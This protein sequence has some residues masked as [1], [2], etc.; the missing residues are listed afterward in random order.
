MSSNLTRQEE[1]EIEL[2]KK[3]LHAGTALAIGGALVAIGFGI[4]LAPDTL[5]MG[6]E[7]VRPYAIHIMIFGE[8]F[9]IAMFILLELLFRRRMISWLKRYDKKD[10]SAITKA[11]G[12]TG[13]STCNLRK[14][15][16]SRQ[17]LQHKH[18]GDT[19]DI[20]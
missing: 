19:V 4:L 12:Q 3:Q 18:V 17:G 6:L 16:Y 1:F 9:F 14:C 20:E 11:S 10:M 8:A 15:R 7:S 13:G 5:P 2:A